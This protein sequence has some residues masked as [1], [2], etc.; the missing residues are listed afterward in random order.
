MEKT[1]Y[2]SLHQFINKMTILYP[3]SAWFALRSFHWYIYKGLCRW[4]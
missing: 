4:L 2:D 3:H 1:M